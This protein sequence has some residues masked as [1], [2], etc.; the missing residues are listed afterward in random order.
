MVPQAREWS[1]LSLHPPLLLVQRS[2]CWSLKPFVCLCLW[3]ILPDFLKFSLA[4]VFIVSDLTQ[5]HTALA[6]HL[7]Q[8]CWLHIAVVVLTLH[9]VSQSS[10]PKLSLILLAIHSWSSNSSAPPAKLVL[11]PPTLISNG[12]F[13]SSQLD[14]CGSMSH[15][16]LWAQIRLQVAAGVIFWKVRS[17]YVTT[18]LN[19]P[20]DSYCT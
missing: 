6:F 10:P 12:G 1:H 8:V 19:P 4:S 16:Y 9:P 18:V 2:Q 17:E 7:S 5:P 14:H 15:A 13:S 20:L 11:K 3:T